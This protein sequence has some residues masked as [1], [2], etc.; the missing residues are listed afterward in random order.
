MSNS[1]IIARRRTDRAV[2][3]AEDV[4]RLTRLW[5]AAIRPLKVFDMFAEAR[6]FA[7][8]VGTGAPPAT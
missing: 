2:R 6:V 3:I 5:P 7:S 4:A 1:T 8:E